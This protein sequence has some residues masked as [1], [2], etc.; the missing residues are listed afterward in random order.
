M[1]DR[2][3]TIGMDRQW[4][5]AAVKTVSDFRWETGSASGQAGLLRDK[6]GGWE[7]KSVGRKRGKD[8]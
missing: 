3:A 5:G 6:T 4:G 1:V 8:K 2:L 7:W